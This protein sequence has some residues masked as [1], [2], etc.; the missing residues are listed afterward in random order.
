VGLGALNRHSALLAAAHATYREMGEY[1]AERLGI[2]A[3]AIVIVPWTQ[4]WSM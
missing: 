4:S 2:D 1:A 3:E